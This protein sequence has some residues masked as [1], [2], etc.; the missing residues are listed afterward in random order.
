MDKC[1]LESYGK[2]KALPKNPPKNPWADLNYI[3]EVNKRHNKNFGLFCDYQI[4]PY[5]KKCSKFPYL[6]LQAYLYL[7]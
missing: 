6:Y 1:Q 4:N 2:W 7:V 5:T 3:E